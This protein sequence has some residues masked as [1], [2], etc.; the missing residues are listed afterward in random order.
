MSKLMPPDGSPRRRRL[1]D[2][3]VWL[4]NAFFLMIDSNIANDP[5]Q[6]TWVTNQ[7]EQ[8]DRRR[9][10]NIVAVFHHPPFS[11][12]PHGGDMVEPATAVI[13]NVYMRC[14]AS[15]MSAC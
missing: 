5:L 2:V 12:G 15:T 7:L 14:F 9:Y 4:R 8:L 6:L 10:V 13:R 3:F 11:S 1:S